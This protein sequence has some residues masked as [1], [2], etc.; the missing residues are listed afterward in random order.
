MSINNKPIPKVA[1]PFKTGKYIGIIFIAII[2]TIVG[3]HFI[4]HPSKTALPSTPVIETADTEEQAKTEATRLKSPSLVYSSTTAA[5]APVKQTNTSSGNPNQFFA[6]QAANAKIITVSAKQLTHTDYKI[7]QGKVISAVLETAIDSDLPGMV[8]A[9]IR[10]DVYSETGDRVLLPKGTRLIGQYNS[11]ITMGQTR[12][13]ILW[14]RAITPADIEIALGSPN[15]NAIGEAGMGGKVDTHFW[16]IFGTNMLLSVLGAS[17]SQYAANAS[18]TNTGVYG[19]PYATAVTQG[20]LNNSNSVLQTNG[21]LPPTIHVKQGSVIQVF[22]AR[23]LD[24]SG[25]AAESNN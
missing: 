20:I 22:V 3:Q 18:N 15:I 17:A 24:F 13:Y 23:D 7:L 10:N 14:T 11:S 6:D 16:K 25:V 9:V 2:A 12:V 1:G 8:R 21:N 4:K 19:N 5:E